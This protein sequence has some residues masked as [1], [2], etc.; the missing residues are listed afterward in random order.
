MLNRGEGSLGDPGLQNGA[1]G[2]PRRRQPAHTV[3]RGMARPLTVVCVSVCLSV[4]WSHGC[5]VRK[6]L[7]WLRCLWG[8]GL[9]PMGPRN[10]VLDGD[11]DP[12]TGR[13]T[14][15]ELSGPLKIIGSLCCSVCSSKRDHSIFSN[16]W[17]D[18]GLQC[19]RL[20]N[21]PPRCGLSSEYFHHLLTWLRP[22]MLWDILLSAHVKRAVAVR[23]YPGDR[24]ASD[25]SSNQWHA[26]LGLTNL[27][28]T[29]V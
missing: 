7:N 6:R 5:A 28:T 11:W 27:L 8:R 1:D 13:G 19:S 29:I 26:Y 14:F 23:K 20:I 15:G 12:P 9:T 2:A 21:V 16:I 10:H 18:V 25:F 17:R 4:R 24:T 22:C 3:Q